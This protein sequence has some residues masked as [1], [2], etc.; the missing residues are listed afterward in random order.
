MADMVRAV[1][2][3]DTCMNILWPLKPQQLHNHD[4]Y[5]NNT[6]NDYNIP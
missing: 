1:V 5:H 2:S 4:N 6:Y 3:A